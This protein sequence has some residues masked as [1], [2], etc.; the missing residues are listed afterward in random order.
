MRTPLVIV[1]SFAAATFAAPST[2]RA[3]SVDPV[4]DR[5]VSAWA[6]MK[7]VRG[8]FEQT[9]SNSLTGSSA[10]AIGRYAQER[11][12]RLSIRFDQADSARIVSD[13][14]N[15]WVYLPASAPGQVI[16]RAAT[17]RGA[18]PIDLTGQ[19]L[20][21][22]R[23]KYTVTAADGRTIDG[24]PARG[25]ILVPKAGTA[26]RFSKA[27]VWVDDDDALIRE[28]EETEPNGV[29]RRIHLTSVELNTPVD[30]RVFAFTVPKGVRIVD[31]TKP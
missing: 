2:V 28:F 1:A 3:Q 23:A 13:G 21:S 17:E 12:N 10:S 20:E 19:F 27:V 4:I 25:L 6:K 11:P 5:A 15:V 7:T 8:T 30:A 31:Q 9:V 18:V 16:K 22:P 26:A 24:H 14:R 29:S